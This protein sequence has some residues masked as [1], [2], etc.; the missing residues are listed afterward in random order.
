MKNEI[1][2]NT[3]K[4]LIYRFSKAFRAGSVTQLLLLAAF[5]FSGILLQGQTNKWYGS[6]DT[7]WHKATNWSLNHEPLANENVIYTKLGD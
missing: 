2:K 3:A 7:D 5:L 1:S 6:T 4:Q